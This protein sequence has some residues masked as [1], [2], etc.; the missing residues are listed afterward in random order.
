MTADEI[1]K[2][3]K[4]KV[5][6]V[7]IADH[8][9]TG[10]FYS[11]T[12]SG[13]RV[14][15]ITT[16]QKMVNKPHL[17]K[18]VVKKGVEWLEQYDR[19]EKLKGPERNLMMMGAQDAHKE[20]SGEAASDGTLT[21]AVIE[22]YV[23]Y[24]LKE[25]KPPDDIKKGFLPDASPKS[26]AGAR[27]AEKLFQTNPHIVP[28]ATEL[29]VGDDVE[30]HSAGQL[31][32]LV[33]DTI[34]KELE[35]WDWKLTNSIE[36]GYAA[37][38]SAYK[39]ML[40]RMSGLKIKRIKVHQLSKNCDKFTTY[41]VAAPALAYRAMVGLSRYYDYLYG[42]VPRIEKDIIKINLTTKYGINKAREI[43][44]ASNRAATDRG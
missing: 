10:H 5:E 7:W 44:R 43:S 39:G 13:A 23:K 32:L 28:I 15:S 27:A 16:K 4:E 11:N 9:A 24:W 34:E 3:I 40:E 6:G 41:K 2:V 19:F 22:N 33:F 25:G 42:P 14:A 38:A 29:L 18:W 12:K 30:M 1:K 17:D 31:D 8:D 21:H 35:L 20:E 36:D 37:Q 26:I